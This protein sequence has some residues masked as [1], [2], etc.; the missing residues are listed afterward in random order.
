MAGRAKAESLFHGIRTKTLPP[1]EFSHEE[2]IRLAWYY[3]TT[4]PLDEACERFDADLRA[5]VAAAGA[6][7]KYHYTI[8]HGLLRLLDTHLDTE[9]KRQDWEA[10][11]QDAKPA[12]DDAMAV[13]LRFWSD[14]ALFSDSARATW[15]EPDRAPLPTRP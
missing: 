6:S 1:A 5:Y 9:A 7:D 10:F 2:H 12:F 8:T 15:E 3:L 14:T 11:K 13:L 4:W